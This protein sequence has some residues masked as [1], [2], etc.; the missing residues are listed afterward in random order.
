MR[1]SVTS[2]VV[3]AGLVAGLASLAGCGG[4][5]GNKGNPFGAPSGAAGSTPTTGAAGST[6]MTGSAGSNTQGSAG[7]NTQGSAGSSTAG[8]AGSTS[9]GTGGSGTGGDGAGGTGPADGGAAG[10]GTAGTGSGGTGVTSDITKVVPA[11]TGCGKDPPADLV[12]GTLVKQMI[13]DMGTKDAN[14]ADAKC[15]A[16]TDTREYWVRLPKNYDKTK[17]YPMVFEG[18]GCGGAGNN[19]YQIPIFDSTVIRVGLTPSHYWQQYHATNPG[20]GCFDDKEG[21]DSVDWVLYEDLWDLLSTTVCFDK[22]RVFAGGNSSGAWFSNEVGCKYAGDATRPIRAIMPN[23]GGLPTDAK[24]VPTCTTHPMAGFWSHETGDTT[25]PFA[26]NIIA[27]NRALIV[28]GCTPM[29]VTYTSATMANAFDPFPV[30]GNTD[31][32][33]QEVQGLPRPL[34]DGRLPARG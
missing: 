33:V 11:G 29:G 3:L 22:N 5:G 24:Y 10:A 12:P 26:G 13:N 15:G 28:N 21:D 4:G 17:A 34:P 27:M 19:L 18:P 32:V 2:S 1:S 14:C 25:N 20:Q 16:W 31:T 8:S 30:G 23:T 9:A 7:S 6:Q